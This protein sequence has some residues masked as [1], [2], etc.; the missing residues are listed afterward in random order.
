M[1]LLQRLRPRLLRWTRIWLRRTGYAPG[2][3]A[4][5]LLEDWQGALWLE[6]RGLE[7]P[8]QEWTRAMRRVLYRE[9]ERPILS[10]TRPLPE[11][12]PDANTSRE[13]PM[14]LADRAR[15]FATHPGH[16]LD[17]AREHG[18]TRRILKSEIT[19]LLLKMSGSSFF[20]NLRHRIARVHVRATST[21]PWSHVEPEVRALIRVTGLL[22]LPPD[23]K[24][25]RAGLTN[26]VARKEVDHPESPESSISPEP[27]QTTE[28]Q[29]RA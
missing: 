27:L 5:Q 21:L 22:D 18:W 10:R 12:L 24:R 16:P 19:A 29:A 15:E 1:L 2:A 6:I 13:I 26:L 23:L 7:D 8:E 17:V 3:C 20:E 4:S 14:E 9:I 11:I 28:S 25:A